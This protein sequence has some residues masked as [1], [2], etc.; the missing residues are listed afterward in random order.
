MPTHE[1][2]TGRCRADGKFAGAALERGVR[3]SIGDQIVAG[4]AGGQAAAGDRVTGL[5]WRR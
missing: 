4:D 1:W 3:L 2:L 5:A